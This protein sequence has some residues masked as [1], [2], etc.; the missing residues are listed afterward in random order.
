M[1]TLILSSL[2]LTATLSQGNPL[3]NRP[4]VPVPYVPPTEAGN[5]SWNTIDPVAAGWSPLGIV[6]LDSFLAS[7]GTLG[8]VVLQD[9]RILMES[10]FRGWTQHDIWPVFSVT[11]SHTA[12][13]LGILSGDGLLDLDDPV[14]AYLG[15]GWTNAPLAAEL[16]IT[17]RDVASM[18]SGLGSQFNLLTSPGQVW[19]YNTPVYRELLDV[20]ETASGLP[21]EEYAA[22]KIWGPIGMNDTQYEPNGEFMLS[23]ARDLARFGLLIARKGKWGTR[24]VLKNQESLELMQ[25]SSQSLNPAYGLL[26]WL[27]GQDGWSTPAGASGTGSFIPSAPSDTTAA[28]GAADQKVFIVPSQGLVVVRIGQSSGVA[29][30]DY[31]EALWQ[32]LRAAS[33]NAWPQK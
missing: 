3:Q 13:Q 21:R 2:L 1:P 18:T 15:A 7:S 32:M 28:L 10:Y 20:I 9:G 30:P 19:F 22:S 8:F 26:W 31:D 23:S 6:Q 25:S 17:I 33:L 14:T 11:K 16:Q 27:N 29:S 24:Q 12:T 4:L 5:D